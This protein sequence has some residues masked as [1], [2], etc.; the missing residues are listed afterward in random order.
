MSPIAKSDG[1]DAPGLVAEFIP[2]VAAELDDLLVRLEDA[3]GE[4]V[5]AHELPDV[6]GGVEFRRLGRQGQD[7]DVVWQ[8]ELFG[9]VP[10][11]LIKDEDRMC[12][13]IDRGANLGQMGVHRL[14]VAPRQDQADSLTFCWT[15]GAED[16]GPLGAQILWGAGPGAA[17][18]PAAGDLVFLTDPSLVLEPDFDLHALIELRPDRFQ[19]GGEVFLKASTANSFCA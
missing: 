17:L 19:L 16:I 11:G 5:V 14:G 7:C 12:A 3:I 13:R 2:S 9:G 18:G 10:A 1:H 15:D 8:A 6:F 4:P